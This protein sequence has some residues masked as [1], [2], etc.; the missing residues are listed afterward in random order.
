[1]IRGQ[2]HTVPS[3]GI[4]GR[5]HQPFGVLKSPASLILAKISFV[6]L[7][8]HLAVVLAFY[9]ASGTPLAAQIPPHLAGPA[10]AFFETGILVVCS[11]PVIYF[12]IVRPY[13]QQR[14]VVERKLAASE[15][16]ARTSEELFRSVIENS[17]SS[18]SVK[19]L[20]GRFLGEPALHRVVWV[21]YG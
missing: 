19:D 15:Q 6:V 9:A 11:A 10:S 13:L 18:F 8:L 21:Q 2:I 4:V 3:Y 7:A 17:P 12:W 14:D 20:D 16:A 5:G 1:M